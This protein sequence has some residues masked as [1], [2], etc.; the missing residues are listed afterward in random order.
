ME[1]ENQLI[2]VRLGAESGGT[3]LSYVARIISADAMIDAAEQMNMN[4]QQFMPDEMSF[5]FLVLME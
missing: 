1:E 3:R 4:I 5:T 2:E